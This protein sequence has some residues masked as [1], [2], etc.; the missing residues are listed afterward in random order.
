MHSK[1]NRLKIY[2]TFYQ[3]D[4]ALITESNVKAKI[5]IFL[6]KYNELRT[7]KKTLQ[8]NYFL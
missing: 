7:I 5:K 1:R 3:N 4:K 8:F 6:Q 2:N